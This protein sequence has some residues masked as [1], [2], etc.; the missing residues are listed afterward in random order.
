LTNSSLSSLVPSG[1][2]IIP[3]RNVTDGAPEGQFVRVPKESLVR[4]V[5][6]S[7]TLPYFD[8]GLP[9]FDPTHSVVPLALGPFGFLM[10]RIDFA[11][12]HALSP[13]VKWMNC[14]PLRGHVCI[15]ELGRHLSPILK[16]P[17]ITHRNTGNPTNQRRG[18][19]MNRRSEGLILLTL[20]T[21]AAAA[22]IMT[23]TYAASSNDTAVSYST[24]L[25]TLGTSS[26]ENN[27]TCRLPPQPRM[28]NQTGAPHM[29]PPWMANLTTEQKQTL[30]VTVTKM[31]ASGATPE[32][33]GNAVNELLKQWGIQIPDHIGPPTQPMNN[34]TA[35]TPLPPQPGMA[36]ST[37]TTNPP[38]PSMVNRT[39]TEHPS[40]PWMA[41]LT[42]EQKQ[43]L[44]DTV[45]TMKASGAT[46][47]QI[48]NAVN[49]LLKQWGIQIPQCP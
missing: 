1:Y 41:N 4:R 32:Q 39:N 3:R 27:S 25:Y 45:K 24:V 18:D 33:I 30:N 14:R 49:E 13:C 23:Q 46:P 36:N 35:G 43:T 26:S 9:L 20:V 11:R 2:R 29:P 42:T 7:V 38:P 48:R 40:A 17:L 34:S 10:S 37:D 8:R 16:N 28:N 21:I 47:E 31:Q 22:G 19:S 5:P 6:I 12:N 44:D 15:W